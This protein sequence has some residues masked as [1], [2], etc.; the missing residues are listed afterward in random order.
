[1]DDSDV[2]VKE[3]IY[4][5]GLKDFGDLQTEISEPGFE[6]EK[7]WVTGEVPKV[8]PVSVNGDTSVIYG[9]FRGEAFSAS[10][11]LKIYIE[12]EEAD[13]QTQEVK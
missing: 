9:W 10:F 1:M 8:M 7:A 3:D 2:F 13:D 4:L 12:Y 5:D 11:Y 6:E